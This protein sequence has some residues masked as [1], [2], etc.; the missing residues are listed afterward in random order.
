[1]SNHDSHRL[2]S[3]K[4]Y[5]SGRSDVEFDGQARF[6]IIRYDCVGESIKSQTLYSRHGRTSATSGDTYR[7][8]GSD[9]KW[10]QSVKGA[11][12]PQVSSA[13]LEF[14]FSRRRLNC[15]VNNT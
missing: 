1:M 5:T 3:I 9:P 8:K 4:F 2:S 6:L 14:E 13:T 12:S 11:A 10:G 15:L 7:E